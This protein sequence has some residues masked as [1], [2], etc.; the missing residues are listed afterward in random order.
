MSQKYTVVWR[1]RVSDE[2]IARFVVS[3]METGESVNDISF[4]SN[5]IEQLLSTQPETRGESRGE[6]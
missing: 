3:A 4:A 1:R 2:D 5:R 6:F